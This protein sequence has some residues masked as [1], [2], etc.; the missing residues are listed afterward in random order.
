MMMVV[1]MRMMA[2]AFFER[3]GP[4]QGQHGDQGG[5]TDDDQ[6]IARSGIHLCPWSRH[7]V[8]GEGILSKKRLENTHDEVDLEAEAEDSSSSSEPPAI[9]KRCMR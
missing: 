6:D 2:P 3:D 9:F 7:D 1:M 4:D 8:D 5:G